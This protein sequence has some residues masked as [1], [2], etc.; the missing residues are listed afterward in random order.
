MT[1]GEPLYTEINMSQVKVDG[2]AIGLLF[3]LSTVYIFFVGIPAVRWFL[4]GALV[5]GLVVS[6]GLYLFHRHFPARPITR[7]V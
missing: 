2:G 1:T 7:I 4:V 3:A 6:L 5:T